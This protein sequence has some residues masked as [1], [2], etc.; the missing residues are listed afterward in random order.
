MFVIIASTYVIKKGIV[1]QA[2]K[3]RIYPSIE[4]QSHL[5]QAF[6]G[7][8]WVWNQSLAAMSPKN[9]AER[10]GGLKPRPSRTALYWLVLVLAGL[11][12]L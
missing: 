6:G 11:Y 2:V 12:T 7:A 5:V 4:Q 9:W 1:L 10:S 3:V 8:R